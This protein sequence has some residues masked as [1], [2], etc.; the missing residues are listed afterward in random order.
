MNKT[1]E[2]GKTIKTLSDHGFRHRFS[3]FL[4]EEV[5]L[6]QPEN[7]K[8]SSFRGEIAGEIGEPRSETRIGS[9]I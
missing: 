1:T 7:T 5:L 3:F 6:I 8:S 2:T 9:P 4:K